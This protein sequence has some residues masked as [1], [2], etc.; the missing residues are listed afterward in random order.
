[1]LESNSN[2]VG[3]SVLCIMLDTWMGWFEVF[4]VI[5]SM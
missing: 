3:C 2:A 5:F 1:M 4:V